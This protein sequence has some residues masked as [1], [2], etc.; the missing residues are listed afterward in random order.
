MVLILNE[1]GNI[2]GCEIETATVRLDRL[3]HIAVIGN[4]HQSIAGSSDENVSLTVA[5]SALDGDLRVKGRQIIAG[6]GQLTRGVI[7]A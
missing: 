4:H 2:G 1:I 3:K 6:I 5:Q 7:I